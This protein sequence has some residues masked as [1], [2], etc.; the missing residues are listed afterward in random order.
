MDSEKYIKN[1]NRELF[2]KDKNSHLT[3]SLWY[4]ENT[5]FTIQF[6]IFL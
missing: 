4:S 3:L 6:Q 2:E 5:L 1:K